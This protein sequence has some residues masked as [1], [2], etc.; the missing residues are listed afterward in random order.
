MR[1]IILIAAALGVAA[2]TRSFDNRYALTGATVPVSTLASTSIG[3]SSDLLTWT[4]L[5][6]E[7]PQ[8]AYSAVQRLRPF[9]LTARPSSADVHGQVPRIRVFI[10]GDYAGD[11]D[12]L[13]SIP[14]RDI[15]SIRRLQPLMAY[16]TMGSFHAGEETL[17]VRLRC[18]VVC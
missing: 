17:L 2:C 4:D 6:T 12:V 15:E 5:V 9:F 13:R 7:A 3:A 11:V 1:P 18:H 10:D 8:D 16:A 14:V